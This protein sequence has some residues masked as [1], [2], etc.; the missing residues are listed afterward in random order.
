MF[1]FTKNNEMKKKLKQ[2]F[3]SVSLVAGVIM[4]PISIIDLII[5]KD[6]IY[7]LALIVCVFAIIG[8]YELITES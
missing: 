3:G 8:G 1:K 7:I 2:T 4:I 5:Y 6:I